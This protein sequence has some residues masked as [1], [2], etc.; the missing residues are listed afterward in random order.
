MEHIHVDK[1][2]PGNPILRYLA[3]NIESGIFSMAVTIEKV[4]LKFDFANAV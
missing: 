2:M 3:N 1:T 4:K